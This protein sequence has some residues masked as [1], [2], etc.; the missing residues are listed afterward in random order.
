MQHQAYTHINHTLNALTLIALAAL[1]PLS[2]QSAL[3]EPA[4]PPATPTEPTSPPTAPQA[5][6]LLILSGLHGYIEP[7]GCTIDLKLGGIERL[8]RSV[9][10]ARARGPVALL[11]AGGHLFE[12]RELPPHRAA[13][14]EAKARLLRATLADLGVEALIPGPQDLALGEALYSALELKHPLPDATVN[15]AGGAPRL[16]RLG[17]LR[18]GV[19]GLG[20]EG[21]PHPT[22]GAHLPPA[23]AARAA[24]A[25]LRAQGAHVIVALTT[26]PRP[27]LRELAREG[28][29]VDLWVL[30]EGALEE[31]SLSPVEGGGLIVEAG[32]RGRHLAALTLHDAASD[33]PLLDPAGDR[34]RRR[35]ELALRL[36]MRRQVGGLGGW[37]GASA[38]ELAAL[39]AELSALDAQLASPPADEGKRVHYTLTPIREDL[40]ADEAVSRAVAAYQA[41][42]RDLNLSVAG[43]VKP[44]PPGG[45]GYA[46]QAECAPCHADAV[47]F[48]ERT[49]HARAWKT[50]EDDNKTFDVECVGCHVTGWQLP[51]GSALGH[52]AGL[53]SVQCEACHG[54]SSRHAE[55]GG[56][57]AGTRRYAP[58]DTCTTCHNPL[59]SPKFNYAEYLKRVLGPGHG[60]SLSTVT[61]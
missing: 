24:A 29:G 4:P 17:D 7:C 53:E 47:Q 39:E 51:G 44:L 27:A 41:S 48:W 3:A 55:V 43:Q 52:T 15:A 11:V 9:R 61:P 35:A 59:H 1:S 45:Q 18:V 28:L 5:P 19:L 30:A 25:L 6:T 31:P 10:E 49:P 60:A 13:Q 22:L 14:D 54:P 40:P 34:A 33:G 8:A 56:G 57:E 58:P 50:L 21:E 38:Q 46:G 12:T 36:K 37:G 20:V 26:L 23:P 16:L 2:P 32:D 42:L